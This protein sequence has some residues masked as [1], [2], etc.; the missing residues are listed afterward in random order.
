[1]NE[2]LLNTKIV[3]EAEQTFAAQTGDNSWLLILII[4]A[5]ISGIIFFKK[6][7][8]KV[9]LS[10]ML[11]FSFISSVPKKSFADQN[12]TITS[13]AE[14]SEGNPAQL[15]IT[16]NDSYAINVSKL[17][18]S[19]L[20]LPQY[21]TWNILIKD[22]YEI[23]EAGSSEN[24]CFDIA[25]HSTFT[26]SVYPNI[27]AIPTG[28]LCD[29]CFKAVSTH[30]NAT[31]KNNDGGDDITTNNDFDFSYSTLLNAD[32]TLLN[33][34]VATIEAT[35]ASIPNTYNNLF[36]NNVSY[37]ISDR[38][39]FMRTLGFEDNIYCKLW[40]EQKPDIQAD[41]GVSILT[42]AY[43]SDKNDLTS[44][45]FNHRKINLGN[46]YAEIINISVGATGGNFE[47]ASN[48]DFGAETQD[49]KDAT[50]EHPD[51]KHKEDHKGLD[52]AANRLLSAYNSYYSKYVD[53]SSDVDK[54]ILINGH[55]RGGGIANLL[56]KHFEDISKSQ[57]MKSFTYTFASPN[58]T[59]ISLNNANN[60]IFNIINLDDLVSQFPGYISGFYK[61]GKDI[62][63]S[64]FE[65]ESINNTPMKTIF[66]N[67]SG[68]GEYNGNDPDDVKALIEATCDLIENREDAYTLDSPSSKEYTKLGSY[69]TEA[70]AKQALNE[71]QKHLEKYNLQFFAKPIGVVQDEVSGDYVIKF[72]C[73]AAFIMQDISNWVFIYGGD[74]A[75]YQPSLGYN[76]TLI[77][78]LLEAI[79]VVPGIVHSHIWMSYNL[80][81]TYDKY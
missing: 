36:L 76:E 80:L 6:K 37:D 2:T 61:Y 44:F 18:I 16:N 20:A 34:D 73:C 27:D 39:A 32:P 81:A 66:K 28:E 1:M 15:T 3:H 13:T 23:K 43:T 25:P 9:L 54:I 50:G 75:K 49:Y 79:G 68:Y 42:P 65:D 14:V 58:T 64:V 60:T 46:R 5:I 69:D 40:P 12:V 67:K 62:D 10:F 63:L 45:N 72:K 47:W 57:N 56:G 21:T 22:N 55:S 7:F 24:I 19:N 8:V 77:N 4:V 17:E 41:P 52:V 78:V 51:W 59:S 71:F 48:F 35:F 26:F 74:T 11:V 30:F 29:I 53:N 70:E 38:L 33:R 31:Y